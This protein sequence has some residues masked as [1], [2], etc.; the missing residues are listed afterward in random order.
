MKEYTIESVDGTK[1]Y[2]VELTDEPSKECALEPF[3]KSLDFMRTREEFK[4]VQLQSY[5]ECGYA[6]PYLLAW[7][8][9]RV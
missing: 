3:L 6:T 2:V 4:T 5:L 7:A 8:T 9:E 1:E